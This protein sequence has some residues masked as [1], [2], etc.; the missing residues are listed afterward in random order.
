MSSQIISGLTQQYYH[1][2]PD[3]LDLISTS[4]LKENIFKMLSQ[5]SDEQFPEFVKDILIKVEGHQL[6]DITDGPGDEK[7]DILTINP[8]GI[9]CLIQCKHTIHYNK[10][11]NGDELDRMVVACMRKD[12]RESVFITNSDLTPQAKKYVTDKEYLR[13][14][15]DHEHPI[16]VEYWN[17][18][19]IWERIKNNRDILNKWFSGFGQTTALRSFRFDVGARE[20]PI[21]IGDSGS[22][23]NSILNKL[24]S[25]GVLLKDAKKNFYTGEIHGH[26]LTVTKSFN[27]D[28]NLGV[29]Y[30]NPEHENYLRHQPISTLTIEVNVNNSLPKY[31]PAALKDKIIQSLFNLVIEP[32]SNGRWWHLVASEATGFIY[33]YD[34]SEPRQVILDSNQTYVMIGSQFLNDEID[35][36]RFDGPGYTLVKDPEDD[37]DSVWL[38]DE[39]GIEVV[40]WFDRELDPVEMY[41]YQ[42]V[43]MFNLKR[44]KKRTFNAVTGI[45]K[46]LLMRVRRFI[47]HTWTSFQFNEDTL[48]WA[49]P[50]DADERQID[51]ISKKMATLNLE[52]LTISNEMRDN[53]LAEAK[54]D[55][56]PATSMY[57]SSL[58][59][60]SL[61]I[62][63]KE[64]IF[65]LKK[66]LLLE[67][68]VSPELAT[69]LL[70]FKFQYDVENGFD[71]MRGE[72]TME[73]NTLELRELLFDFFTIRGEKMMDI[74]IYNNPITLSIRY[75]EGKIASSRELV[76]GY[77]QEFLAT[78][79]EL[80]L[81][82]N[83]FGKK[84]NEE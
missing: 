69:E 1:T 58:R 41:N 67:D 39:S 20:L 7:Q 76:E 6:I 45:N 25:N 48:I 61:P 21:Q 31:S 34:I 17:D 79:D 11:Y 77:L 12:C 33:L 57:T 10:N 66:D 14:Q 2:L 50:E 9:R 35:Y 68:K 83:N 44:F 53:F 81:L 55:L 36:C 71:N 23:L 64:R 46:N 18:L 70:I 51:R 52:V 4:P 15:P 73:S 38:H 28:A 13:G 42:V 3:S 74:G 29:Q 37:E 82:I 54:N 16:S 49:I 32:L 56:P 40:Q 27:I 78:Y 60:M 62:E 22:I 43:Q 47:P 59:G 84:T 63:L 5:I 80:K 30:K 75:Q 19:R 24:E 26:L 72:E 8:A 65:W